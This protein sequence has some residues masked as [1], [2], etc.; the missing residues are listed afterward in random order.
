[1]IEV[2]DSGRG[3]DWQKVLERAVAR[4]L[5]AET[6]GDLER[7]LFADGLSTKDRV[8]ETSGRGVGMA[9]V[10]AAVQARGGI[11]QVRS[12]ETG[13][14]LVTMRWPVTAIARAPATPSQLLALGP[15]SAAGHPS[16]GE[17]H[18]YVA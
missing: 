14:T 13:G 4:G 3:V 16:A 1:V 5:P 7:A 2:E 10:A 11:I 9:A 8:D 18:K 17:E 12:R 15:E 6:H